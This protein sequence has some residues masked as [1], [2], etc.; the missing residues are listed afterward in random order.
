[1]NLE[2]VYQIYHHIINDCI[3][4]HQNKTHLEEGSS[5]YTSLRDATKMDE[6][7]ERFQTAVDPPPLPL[8]MVPVSGNHVHAFHTI[9]PWHLFQYICD[10]IHY[11]KIAP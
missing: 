8:K 4:K 11:K 3:E 7:S 6:F 5:N 10:H 9:W 1:M 2:S